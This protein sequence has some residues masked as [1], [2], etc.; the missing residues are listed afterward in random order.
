M[1]NTDY[2]SFP[3]GLE[4]LTK[5]AQNRSHPFDGTEA[6]LPAAD[7]QIATWLTEQFDGIAETDR[8]TT[9]RTIENKARNI[10]EEF[11]GQ[12]I[13]LFMHALLISVLRHDSPPPVAVTLFQRIWAEHGDW[14]LDNLTNRWK[15]SAIVTFKDFG[16]NEAQRRPALAL[17]VFFNTALIH[18]TERTYSGLLPSQLFNWRDRVNPDMFL[19]LHRHA[20]KTGDLDRNMFLYLWREC[21]NADPVVRPLAL[22]LINRFNEDRGT[23]FRRLKRYKRILG[24]FE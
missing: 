18:E 13:M 23:V 3:G 9:R 20:L 2:G 12:P 7:A 21:E 8:S 4:Y 11:V 14:M 16:K 6:Y 1:I 19:G 24:I 17:S 10:S 22:D 5:R 15:L